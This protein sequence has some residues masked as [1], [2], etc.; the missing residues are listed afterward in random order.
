M[1]DW[2]TEVV[3]VQDTFFLEETFIPFDGTILDI[4]M[5]KKVI[6]EISN[7]GILILSVRESTARGDR[8]SFSNKVG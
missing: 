1:R 7:Y 8:I 6:D 4:T 2:T 3:L 5:L